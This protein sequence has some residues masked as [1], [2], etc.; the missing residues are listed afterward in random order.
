MH[1]ILKALARSILAAVLFGTAATMPMSAQ[2]GQGDV[3]ITGTVV[4]TD[5][6]PLQGATIRM[7]GSNTI[8]TTADAQGK[9]SLKV[10]QG[11]TIEV[12]YMGFESQTA[13]VQNRTKFAFTLKEDANVLEDVVVIGYGSVKKSDL[14]GSVANVKMSDIQNAPVLSVDNALQGRIAGADFMSTHGAPGATT[15]IRIR[16]TR[17]ISASNEPLFVVDGII[18]AIHDL[19]DTNSDDLASITA[20]KDASPPA[21]HGS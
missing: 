15:T 2:T 3:N 13:K 9:F 17:S 5:G 6:L 10:N 20:P 7:I 11:S 1:N 21:I 14:T 4:D 12:L 19:H 18:D 16:G 8:Y